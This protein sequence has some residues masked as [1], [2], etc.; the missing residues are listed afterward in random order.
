[1]ETEEENQF[2]TDFSLKSMVNDIED[3]IS[4][5]TQVKYD[6]NE[7][8]SID[9]GLGGIYGDLMVFDPIQS[10]N[11]VEGSLSMEQDGS[12]ITP[13][14]YTLARLDDIN[15]TLEDHFDPEFY[16]TLQWEF[17]IMLDINHL[18][19]L[20]ASY[21]DEMIL[22]MDLEL[23]DSLWSEVEAL[24][25]TD[26]TPFPKP[27][28]NNYLP[29]GAISN[30]ILPT[31][32]LSPS[33]FMIGSSVQYQLV[34]SLTSINTPQ[35]FYPQGWSFELYY[36]WLISVSDFMKTYAEENDYA[37]GSTA[38]EDVSINS[39]LNLIGVHSFT[40]R[41]NS[42]GIAWSMAEIDYEG[43]QELLDTIFGE[44]YGISVGDQIGAM[45]NAYAIE[46]ESFVGEFSVALEYD[47]NKVLASYATYFDITASL[48]T[49]DLLEGMTDAPDIN[50]EEISINGYYKF[51]R[52]GFYAPSVSQIEEG[53]L[54]DE[55][56]LTVNDAP[57]GLF[58]NIPGYP[59]AIF[60]LVSLIAIPFL[61]LIVKKKK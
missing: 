6:I 55:R 10:L 19:E 45:F 4:I 35:L 57:I 40:I 16:E 59:P 43:I 15:T 27:P 18:E 32:F 21:F 42:I 61:Y 8:Y 26:G 3:L 17:G 49:T 33:Y 50:G 24:N 47:A 60:G 7:L 51:V 11:Y 5:D 38:L 31:M 41:D 56:D 53:E 30:T 34:N 58:A 25:L 36:N 29:G 2:P 44:E 54:G 37:T 14:E 9:M 39:F 46:P 23:D 48:N 22:Q 28:I 13:E 12:W 1:M 52:D 20:D